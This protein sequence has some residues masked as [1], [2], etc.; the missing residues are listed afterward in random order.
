MPF[1]FSD[2]TSQELQSMDPETTV[3]LFPVGPLENHGPHLPLGLDLREAE[4]LS[5]KLGERIEAQKA[6][7]TGVIMPV[8]PLG[9]QADTRKLAWT[10]RPYV[11]RDWLVDACK[12]L[13]RAGFRHFVCLSGHLGP[14]QLTAI[15]EA[16]KMVMRSKRWSFSK[17]KPYLVSASSAL[18]SFKDAK[19]SLFRPNP[20]EHGGERDTSIALAI[21]AQSVRAAYA[22][23]PEITRRQGAKEGLPPGYWGNPAAAKPEQGE[24]LME[25]ALDEIFPKLSAIW[26][27]SNP[28]LFFRSWYSLLPPNQSFFKAWILA[29]LFL[30]IFLGWVYL[31]TQF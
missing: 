2:L 25:S 27:G 11:L 29:A 3:F 19:K 15:E 17:K 9:V 30:A 4:R 7:W 6:P 13:S 22:H 14:K 23:L 20:P 10:V 21:D 1:L 18:V 12:G 28:R 8:A 16:G 24:G 5:W 26:E 31:S